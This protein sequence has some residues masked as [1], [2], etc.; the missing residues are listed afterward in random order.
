MTKKT[1]NMARLTL[2]LVLAAMGLTMLTGSAASTLRSTPAAGGRQV[3]EVG[4]PNVFALT[5][6]A[7]DNEVVLYRRATNGTL[8]LVGRIATN[9]NGTGS[10]LD[11]QGALILNENNTRL[12]ACNAGNDTIS[13]FAVGNTKPTLIQVINSGGDMPVS[14]TIHGNLLYALN[15]GSGANIFGFTVNPDGTLTQLAGS[16][17]RLSTLIGAPAEISFNP[18]GNV[19]IVTNKATDVLV[20]PQNIIDTFTVAANG[21]PS[22]TPIANASFGIRPFGFAVRSDGVI[23][24]AEAFNDIPN[25]SAA[26]SYQVL[27]NGNL[28]VIS[29]S[30]HETQTAGCWIAITNN[31]QYAYETNTLSDT[32]SSFTVAANGSLSLLNPV[33]AMTGAMSGPVDMDLSADGQYLH[34]LLTSAGQVATYRIEANG[35]LTSLGQ[36][37]G[38]APMAGASG[39][40]AF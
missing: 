36:V 3:I 7:E 12:Y 27:A 40:A 35:S 28:Q 38:I 9:G 4:T 37:G 5:N 14:L 21:L 22:A 30:V 31:G 13:V 18:A 11:S 10:R 6:V 2:L 24:V 23:V 25:Q 32:I 20:P 15:A 29:G 19:L 16:F 33:A 39:L 1:G 26:S 8:T 34:V 17:R